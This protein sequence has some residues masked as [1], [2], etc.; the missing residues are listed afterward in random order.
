MLD[1]KLGSPVDLLS[2]LV[3][4]F[5]SD[6]MPWRVP[7]KSPLITQASHCSET[8]V[9]WEEPVLSL[10]ETVEDLLDHVFD[11][12]VEPMVNLEGR[13]KLTTGT[14]VTKEGLKNLEKTTGLNVTSNTAPAF[15]LIRLRGVRSI[16]YYE[17]EF[18]GLNRK[19]KVM[20]WL[21]PE[22]RKAIARLRLSN[23]RL[24]GFDFKSDI[25]ARQAGRYLQYF[26]DFGTHVVTSLTYGEQLFQ[27]FALEADA[28]EV[29]RT[30]FGQDPHTQLSGMS[31]KG[32]APY[33]QAPWIR[34]ASPVLGADGLSKKIVLEKCLAENGQSAEQEQTLLSF[35]TLPDGKVSELLADL[36]AR[37]IIAA[38]FSCQALYLEDFRADIWT[39]MLRAS[40]EQKFRKTMLTGWYKRRFFCPLSFFQGSVLDEQDGVF[41][42][43]L[44]EMPELA[45][46]LDMAGQSDQLDIGT[47]SLLF[48]V[49]AR[50]DTGHGSVLSVSQAEP[51]AEKIKAFS[52]DGV[53][54]LSDPD[55]HQLTLVEGAW[56][57]S[58]QTGA[59]EVIGAPLDVQADLLQRH[60][61]Q[62]SLYLRLFDE[63]QGPMFKD[64]IGL[65]MKRCADWVFNLAAH[66]DRLLSL[67]WQALQSRWGAGSLME[68]ALADQANGQGAE[69]AD[70]LSQGLMWLTQKHIH[71]D[72]PPAELISRLKDFYKNFASF[73]QADL[74]RG[75]IDELTMCLRDVFKNITSSRQWPEFIQA[76]MHV[77]CQLVAPLERGAS[78]NAYMQGDS[79]EARLWNSILSIRS[80]LLQCESILLS[81]R[82]RWAEAIEKIENEPISARQMIANPGEEFVSAVTDVCGEQTAEITDLFNVLI[83]LSQRLNKLSTSGILLHRFD[84]LEREWGESPSR[85]QLPLLILL[86]ELLNLSRAIGIESENLESLSLIE[87][88]SRISVIAA[89]KG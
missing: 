86:L 57:G 17:P 81:C 63:L 24:E 68:Q 60:Q 50:P 47:D 73:Q 43:G 13:T 29:I 36:P 22:G 80:R 83:D 78:P 23:M 88:S 59:V 52:V 16:Q 30:Q 25:T 67:K 15:M 14:L 62:L 72:H 20:K 46:A 19:E 77:G 84:R 64:E 37:D 1:I 65:S 76:A 32:L 56:L 6:D 66:D 75:Q 70:M 33:L 38:S 26:E 61:G 71:Q 89:S 11:Y 21:S 79:H 42:S 9:C 5:P 7:E 40:F 3:A 10:H 48:F 45:L 55:G 18:Y 58:S 4:R 53:V 41:R 69:L 27:I 34:Q 54:R 51:C 2:G 87:L 28:V 82:G 49:G 12:G 39:R 35:S 74:I 31:A 85:S 44:T 8:P